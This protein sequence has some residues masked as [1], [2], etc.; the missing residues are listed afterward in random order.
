MP[1]TGWNVLHVHNCL[2]TN[3]FASTEIPLNFPTNSAQLIESDRHNQ[4]TALHVSRTVFSY[5][6]STEL[7]VTLAEITV[8]TRQNDPYMCQLIWRVHSHRSLSLL[9]DRTLQHDQQPDVNRT[10]NPEQFANSVKTIDADSLQ[11]T[12]LALRDQST[13]SASMAH[14]E[15]ADSLPTICLALHD[16]GQMSRSVSL[17]HNSEIDDESATQCV[18][19]ALFGQV[20]NSVPRAHV[21]HN[22]ETRLCQ[23]QHTL[24]VTPAPTPAANTALLN[25]Q[26]TLTFLAPA[27]PSLSCAGNTTVY[28]RHNYIIHVTTWINRSVSVFIRL[29]APG[30]HITTA[31]R[32]VA[33]L[34][35]QHNLTSP[36]EQTS[37][38]MPIFFC[39]LLYQQGYNYDGSGGHSHHL[40]LPVSV[41]IAHCVSMS[42][43]RNP[44]WSIYSPRGN[45]RAVWSDQPLHLKQ[46][47]LLSTLTTNNCTPFTALTQY[48]QDRSVRMTISHA[49]LSTG[50]NAYSFAHLAEQLCCHPQLLPVSHFLLPN[51]AGPTRIC[52]G[53]PDSDQS[54]DNFLPNNLQKFGHLVLTLNG[55][56]RLHRQFLAMFMSAMIDCIP[57]SV[58]RQY[59]HN[60]SNDIAGSHVLHAKPL[61]DGNKYPIVH[62]PTDIT[63]QQLYTRGTNFDLQLP[64]HSAEWLSCSPSISDTTV[65]STQCF[66]SDGC[67]I[68]FH[69]IFHHSATDM[70]AFCHNIKNCTLPSN[71]PGS[72]SVG[73]LGHWLLSYGLI[74]DVQVDRTTDA[75]QYHRLLSQHYSAT[76]GY[77]CLITSW[78]GTTR[79]IVPS[80]TSQLHTGCHKNT[81]SG[82][83]VPIT[84]T[85]HS[86]RSTNLLAW[87][88][89][90]S[91]GTVTPSNSGSYVFIAINPHHCCIRCHANPVSRQFLNSITTAN[92]LHCLCYWPRLWAYPSNCDN[93]STVVQTQTIHEQQVYQTTLITNLHSD[94]FVL[95]YK[96]HRPFSLKM[97]TISQHRS[98]IFSA[99]RSTASI[100]NPVLMLDTGNATCKTQRS[101]VP[102]VCDSTIRI[103]FQEPLTSTL[104]YE[105]TIAHLSDSPQFGFQSTL[106]SHGITV[107]PIRAQQELLLSKTTWPE[108]PYSTVA[109]AQLEYHRPWFHQYLSTATAYCSVYTSTVNRHTYPRFETSLVALCDTTTDP[110]AK[111][112]IL[113]TRPHDSESLHVHTPTHHSPG[114]FP[115][116]LEHHQ[117][118]ARS[119]DSAIDL[120][121]I[122]PPVHY[123]SDL[124]Y[125][126]STTNRTPTRTNLESATIH[127][128]VSRMTRATIDSLQQSCTDRVNN[129][130]TGF[131]HPVAR[132]NSY[133]FFPP[134][135]HPARTYNIHEMH[136]ASKLD[137]RSS[138]TYTSVFPVTSSTNGDYNAMSPRYD[139]HP[140]SKLSVPTKPYTIASPAMP[141]FSNVAAEHLCGISSIP[142]LRPEQP[143]ILAP[144][145]HTQSS[146]CLHRHKCQV[147][148]VNSSSLHSAV[149]SYTLLH[150]TTLDQR[151]DSIYFDRRTI[152][153][154]A[155]HVAQ[156]L[157]NP[158]KLARFCVQYRAQGW[159]TVL[160][161]NALTN[162][163]ICHPFITSRIRIHLHLSRNTSTILPSDLPETRNQQFLLLSTPSTTN[164]T[165]SRPLRQCRHGLN[166][167]ASQQTELPG[168]SYKYSLVHLTSGIHVHHLC[169]EGA[170]SHLQLPH[171]P[172]G[173][174]NCCSPDSGATTAHHNKSTQVW[175]DLIQYWRQP[176]RTPCW[177]I[178]P[179]PTS[180]YDNRTFSC[181]IYGS[182][183]MQA[184]ADTSPAPNTTSGH[185]DFDNPLSTTG[186]T[187]TAHIQLMQHISPQFNSC[188]HILNTD[189]MEI[190]R[191]PTHLMFIAARP[192][193]QWPAFNHGRVPQLYSEPLWCT[194]QTQFRHHISQQISPGQH[195]LHT[196]TVSDRVP[197]HM[198]STTTRP[199]FLWPA[200]NHGPAPQL[201]SEPH[202]YTRLSTLY[203]SSPVIPL[204]I[205]GTRHDRA[206]TINHDRRLHY[207][208]G[209]HT[210]LIDAFV[211]FTLYDHLSLTLT[212]GVTTDK[213]LCSQ[214]RSTLWSDIYHNGY[215]TYGPRG[216]TH[217][218]IFIFFRHNQACVTP[219]LFDHMALEQHIDTRKS[220][221]KH[222]M[223]DVSWPTLVT[224][225]FQHFYATSATQHWQQ[226][227]GNHYSLSSHTHMIMTA[228]KTQIVRI[229]PPRSWLL[230]SINISVDNL[231]VHMLHRSVSPI[232]TSHQLP[233]V[234]TRTYVSATI[235]R[236]S[237]SP[238][239]TVIKSNGG[240]LQSFCWVSTYVSP[241]DSHHGPELNIPFNP[242]TIAPITLLKCSNTT[243]N[244]SHCG[245]IRQDV[246]TVVSNN[247]GS[248]APTA[249]KSR[250][251]RM[252]CHAEPALCTT[253]RHTHSFNDRSTR[254]TFQPHYMFLAQ[255]PCCFAVNTVTTIMALTD[256]HLWTVAPHITNSTLYLPILLHIQTRI[257]TH[258]VCKE[259]LHFGTTRQYDAE[260]EST[261]LPIIGTTSA[262]TA[263]RS[264]LGNLLYHH[265]STSTFARSHQFLDSTA[266]QSLQ[267]TIQSAHK[268]SMV[269]RSWQIPRPTASLLPVENY[270]HLQ[271][272]LRTVPI[273]A[274]AETMTILS[275]QLE[276]YPRTFMRPWH[277]NTY[278]PSIYTLT[279]CALSSGY[280]YT[281][282]WTTSSTSARLRVVL[283]GCISTG[284]SSEPST[285]AAYTIHGMHTI[286][287][288]GKPN[289][290]YNW[291][292]R[293]SDNSCQPCL[294]TCSRELPLQATTLGHFYCPSDFKFR[295]LIHGHNIIL[296]PQK[297]PPTTIAPNT[298]SIFSRLSDTHTDSRIN[299]HCSSVGLP[300]AAQQ[301]LWPTAPINIPPD[302]PTDLQAI[303]GM[304]VYS[305]IT[306]STLADTVISFQYNY[307]ILWR[308][309]CLTLLRLHYS[310]PHNRDLDTCTTY[311]TLASTTD[312]S[313]LAPI[314]VLCRPNASEFSPMLPGTKQ[315][316]CVTYI[317]CDHSD[318]LRILTIMD[319]VL[320]VMA[321]SY[322]SQI[323]FGNPFK[324]AVFWHTCPFFTTLPMAL[325]D[326]PTELHSTPY[327]SYT[328]DFHRVKCL[329]PDST[330]SAA[331]R[332][333]TLRSKCTSH[334]FCPPMGISPRPH[335]GLDVPDQSTSWC[336]PIIAEYCVHFSGIVIPVRCFPSTCQK[337]R[338]YL[339]RRQLI[340]QN[341]NTAASLFP[342][343]TYTLG[344]ISPPSAL[345]YWAI[346]AH[347]IRQHLHVVDDLR[348]SQQ[349]GV[350]AQTHVTAHKLQHSTNPNSGLPDRNSGRSEQTR[351]PAHAHSS[352]YLC[353]HKHQASEVQ[354]YQPYRSR[355]QPVAQN[356]NTLISSLN[357][358]PT[359]TQGDVNALAART[360]NAITTHGIGHGKSTLYTS[361]ALRLPDYSSQQTPVQYAKALTGS[362]NRCL[363]CTS[364]RLST[365]YISFR[366]VQRTPI[367]LSS[368]SKNVSVLPNPWD[369]ELRPIFCRNPPGY[370]TCIRVSRTD[371]S[372]LSGTPSNSGTELR[373]CNRSILHTATSSLYF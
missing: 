120:Y 345:A 11:P 207:E 66:H 95:W 181:R 166:C 368:F 47:F 243:A 290:T 109:P 255:F 29:H 220:L 303:L 188:L 74:D 55:A 31:R 365:I 346:T 348:P 272:F 82:S 133:S 101:T 292:V 162:C 211:T 297:Q 90:Q 310:R 294:T 37:D 221:V 238:P 347:C 44:D 159:T 93:I 212:L 60:C 136:D 228:L 164:D 278:E 267:H 349:P 352:L 307:K 231:F 130:R 371:L 16:Q 253:H 266:S 143:G 123:I 148:A 271:S 240:E 85:E 189:M 323:H 134:E 35:C 8:N 45:I 59:K 127:T 86:L 366:S 350:S 152:D 88:N 71:T 291:Y 67:P 12:Q 298:T 192:A 92:R 342:L 276:N 141:N 265:D 339:K 105:S 222:I 80:P 337:S 302:L 79:P 154:L 176:P 124:Q 361:V 161:T 331:T 242:N 3:K 227:A 180:T 104:Q 301:L 338:H 355:R 246:S 262:G 203:S 38:I 153:L 43:F 356:C 198:R 269:D 28:S 261:T 213:P 335:R 286:S 208:S 326:L 369:M 23:Q 277:Y 30:L 39:Q 219:N 151:P 70:V 139:S 209:G 27:I 336:L 353:R 273:A 263:R 363:L 287:D 187:H 171:H 330:L 89:N 200:F 311:I 354:N 201:H 118:A 344:D 62:L 270:V 327:L 156:M 229:P 65:L 140:D 57:F 183:T 150:I 364:G 245:V 195:A 320:I 234:L 205:T 182:S 170:D 306:V 216:C 244:T 102:D 163:G 372:E 293:P 185:S 370:I 223:N 362:P 50:S 157:R 110:V 230:G 225:N 215:H 324:S 175:P 41:T 83:L 168:D 288:P 177:T 254:P 308:F 172:A 332:R 84:I 14:G 36:L 6:T 334:R 20:R 129:D 56:V 126:S 333:V 34:L 304:D 32:C 53:I 197:A 259:T 17:A 33:V 194:K 147:S 5:N 61:T 97:D 111:H 22:H 9:I 329:I 25:T 52:S 13:W 106:Y 75:D 149:A 46:R 116:Y 319:S 165:P 68:L 191:I 217:S 21:G 360:Y 317:V 48:E 300:L 314:L 113:L 160:E 142:G 321:P 144:M 274:V 252:H 125:A 284:Y 313:N 51:S 178:T 73:V 316:S 15:H 248:Y 312:T 91:N 4:A 256:W 224:Y 367:S 63:V 107:L 119:C 7:W 218:S 250:N 1:K 247:H 98:T 289:S 206:G 58:L 373:L 315:W 233:G 64:C 112:T 340:T 155:N 42:E 81:R 174:S 132:V 328:T 268:F 199:T 184:N 99:D 296:C 131:H 146:L 18:H 10:N 40:T 341:Y 357:P 236:H 264:Q 279:N 204:R 237:L 145:T 232:T 282:L 100:Y 249:V 251:C 108:T 179:M 295:S 138:Q 190:R 257:P 193:I 241:Y 239:P 103:I 78:S 318:D 72:N 283:C 135:P 359:Y 169:P 115:N 173:R 258:S 322:A 24:H 235:F 76:S 325:C 351:F 358:L 285:T 96:Q 69:R 343:L 309:Q 94:G 54:G 305:G 26:I 49:E 196:D 260:T 77:S 214:F 281:P 2:D 117:T 167:V 202:W 186:S 210:Q 87:D 280:G 121:C 299:T 158:V 137:T 114:T 128:P 226:P 122:L 19:L 275:C